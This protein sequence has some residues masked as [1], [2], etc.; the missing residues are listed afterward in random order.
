MLET[1][2]QFISVRTCVT[3]SGSVVTPSCTQLFTALD[4]RQA[5]CNTYILEVLARALANQRLCSVFQC[6][7]CNPA[8][9]LTV[10]WTSWLPDGARQVLRGVRH[11]ALE[12]PGQQRA[13][14]PS[15]VPGPVLRGAV[16][17]VLTSAGQAALQL[18]CS[19]LVTLC[20]CAGNRGCGKGTDIIGTAS[21]QR[22][23]AS[24]NRWLRP[25]FGKVNQI[26]QCLC[27]RATEPGIP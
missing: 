5:I 1:L 4:L 15:T 19:S 6:A 23:S 24:R 9:A 11:Q 22:M 26:V 7:F 8:K 3:S 27:T 13:A 21:P 25:N 14:V 10:C 12:Q 16:C 17:F 2:Q 18:P 20:F